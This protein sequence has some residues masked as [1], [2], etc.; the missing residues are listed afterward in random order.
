MGIQ[1]A[2]DLAAAFHEAAESFADQLAL[3]DGKEQLTYRQLHDR[4]TRAARAIGGELGSADDAPLVMVIL[5]PSTDLICA[6][7][8]TIAAGA[9]YLPVDAATPD[10]YVRT[11]VEDARPDLL[12]T[13]AA[14]ASRLEDIGVAVLKVDRL[15]R[16]AAQDMAAPK[17]IRHDDPAYVI[18]TSGSTGKPKGV[19]VGHGAMLNSTAARCEAYGVPTRMPLVHSIAFDLSSGVV[20]WALLSGGTLIINRAP[21]SDVPSTLDLIRRHAVTH[22]VYPAS[23]YAPFLDR[24]VLDPPTS[25]E[26]VM[27][28]S[29]R[30]SSVLIGRHAELLP[31]ASLHNEYG[32]SEA[33][34]W[35]SYACVY[36]GVTGESAALTL[37]KPI[38]NTGYLVR[39]ETGGSVAPGE[40]GELLI[41]G[42][43]LA[44]GY[45]RR[46]D[47]TAERFVTTADGE[48][49]YRTGDVVE[50]T[51]D[52]CYVFAGRIDR[53]L[54]VQGNRIEAGH[55][56]TLL[57]S[58]PDIQQAHVVSRDDSGMGSTLV[59][60][61][62]LRSGLANTEA[63]SDL[64]SHLRSQ[65]PAYMVPSAHVVLQ[66]LPRTLN[67]KIDESLLPAPS[68]ATVTEV[69]EPADALEADLV[70]KVGEI[71]GAGIGVET[72]LNTVGANSLAFVRISAAITGTH[73]VEIPMSALFG[74]PTVRAFAE[75]I[76]S[77]RRSDRPA[78]IPRGRH[79]ATSPL[80][81]QQHQ[82]W[83]LHHLSPNALAYN[84]Q[85][86]LRLTG[87]LDQRMLERALSSIV[88]RH[89]ILRTTF[90]D[91][92]DGPVQVVHAPWD[93]SVGLTDL[94]GIEP[95]HRREVMTEDKRT[96]M[97]RLFDIAELPLVR[98]QL[99]RLSDDSWE[100]FQS[101]HHFVHDGWSASL[102][103]KEI[104]DAYQAVSGDRRD[105]IEPL[106]VQYRDYARWYQ[107]WKQSKNFN[108]QAAYWT[109]KLD[110]C[111]AQ[112]VTF[113]S[114]LTRP[115]K[116]GFHGAC[117]RTDIPAE[118]IDR[119]DVLC[120]QHNVTRFAFFLA[121]FGILVWRYT[122]EEDFVIG[123]ALSNRRQS[124]TAPMLGMFV[125][126]LPL[127]LT[128]RPEESVSS[129]V[130]A[131]MRTILEAQDNQEF[132]LIEIIKRLDLP[133]DPA[134]NPLFQLMF[135]FHDS[136]RPRFELDGLTGELWIDHN[137][138][139]KNDLNVVCVPNPAEPGSEA[140][141]DG[142]NILWEYNREV[143]TEEAA[144][145]L[146]R[147]FE[148]I[149]GVIVE[150]WATPVAEVDLL[151][152]ES[153]SRVLRYGTGV[154]PTA[155]F[156]TLHGG[157]N[158]AI[159]KAPQLVAVRQDD[160]SVTYSDLD[161]LSAGIESELLDEGVGPGDVV[162]IAGPMSATVIA[163]W[164]AV[165]R[166]GATYLYVDQDS[167]QARI[168]LILAD[169][170]PAAIVCP[171]ASSRLFRRSGVKV[172]VP[173]GR[174]AVRPASPP[175][176]ED[177]PAYL[178]YTSGS[179]GTPKAVVTSHGNAVAALHARTV[180][181]GSDA[182]CTLVTL[183]AIF[184]VAGSMVFWTL[185][186]GGTVV[187]PVPGTHRD[188]EVIRSLV[189]RNAVSHVNFVASFYRQFLETVP[190]GWASSLKVIAIGGEACT[191]DLVA[192]HAERV[193]EAG[194]HN[195]YGPTEATVWCSAST[196]HAAGGNTPYGQ[197]TVGRPLAGYSMY[198]LDDRRQLVPVGARGELYVGG[199]GVALGYLNRPELTVDRFVTI[200]SG[201][202][203]GSRLYRTGDESRLRQNG[204][205]EIIG[206]LD[207]QVKIRGFRIETGEVRRCLTDHP[208]VNDA[209]V[210]AEPHLGHTRLVA[211]VSTL[212]GPEITGVLEDWLGSRLPSYMV[213]AVTV[214]LPSLPLTST[215][216]VDR[217]R[218]PKPNVAVQ[219]IREVV[220]AESPAQQ[221][222]LDLW[223]EVLGRADIGVDDDFFQIGGDSLQSIRLA[224]RARAE[225]ISLTVSQILQARTVRALAA[226]ASAAGAT[227]D[228]DRRPSGSSVTL[229]AIQNWFFDQEF[230]D[231]DHFNQARIYELTTDADTAVV[232]AATSRVVARHEAFRTR[233][234]HRT[235]VL[236]DEPTVSVE[237]RSVSGAGQVEDEME[238]IQ[239]SLDVEAGRMGRLTVFENAGGSERWLGVVLH[240]LVVDAVSW[241]I[242]AEEIAGAVRGTSMELPPGPGALAVP[243]PT[244]AAVAFWRQV[245]EAPKPRL[246]W[247]RS[248]ARTPF[249]GLAHVRRVHSAAATKNLVYD[250]PRLS[251]TSPRST[252]LA[253]LCLALESEDLYV[254]LEGHGRNGTAEANEI[255]G[256]L[257][258]MAPALLR[259]GE[260]V[261][262]AAT[263]AEF[264]RQLR[265]I[266]DDGRDF[267]VA[268]HVLRNTELGRLV[269]DIELPSITF[270]YLGQASGTGRSDV[271]R[272]S[273][274]GTGNAVGA[275]NVLPTPFDVTLAVR[276]NR[277]ETR[278]SFDPAVVDTGFAHAVLD[279]FE[280]VLEDAAR[281][282]ELTNTS[283]RSQFLVHPIGGSVDWYLP[284]AQRLTPEWACI[285]VAQGDTT[286]SVE[287]LAKTYV[288]GLR[289]LQPTGP[290]RLVGWSF[291]ATVAYQMAAE[292]ESQDEVVSRLSLLDPPPISDRGDGVSPLVSHLRMLLPG[293]TEDELRIAITQTAHLGLEEKVEA[294]GHRLVDK[295]GGEV[296]FELRQLGLL[297][298]NNEALAA[299]RP[300]V[301]VDAEIDLVYSQDAHSEHEADAWS[302]LSKSEVVTTVVAE[303][304]VSMLRN[305]T[306]VELLGRS[307]R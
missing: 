65:A 249:G 246:P 104:R 252:L 106:A 219:A 124:E 244:P 30:W 292:I 2:E 162:A 88:E 279:R 38:L 80:S 148:H 271:I 256:W 294:L 229:T 111:P 264:E 234:S 136:P 127:R 57:M 143:L 5:E 13:S 290:Y 150:H 117:L 107:E 94:R 296:D 37:G 36:N 21:L 202:L 226:V 299:W 169:A 3:V 54:K 275:E 224:A 222:L 170:A 163:S 298:R 147:D 239:H 58:H 157:V 135:A 216:K 260:A 255:V 187:L 196:V 141:H 164:L 180:F 251:A 166:R 217:A 103:L 121:A 273:T 192:L 262:L 18:Y 188:P 93:V 281:F 74:R 71:L 235:A 209:C 247:K 102:F 186:L 45:L 125:N 73:G 6:L 154:E 130:R 232:L 24:V 83:F 86:T 283:A 225:G 51:E 79:E 26:H 307:V 165:L 267:G 113:D 39:S 90:H 207:D 9:A 28:G 220:V 112:G 119:V 97:S 56:E 114:D 40:R 85:F 16:K 62:V 134:R 118:M 231:P 181:F 200:E 44:L 156:K 230:A 159:E 95:A 69:S 76:R 139:A 270:N 140:S 190:P 303:S 60:Y 223:Q 109:D 126:A 241:D 78:L 227:E 206:R 211:Y 253:A 19:V 77:A 48:R 70:A 64:D 101:E 27:I 212:A 284:L 295:P 254:Q 205:F 144:A 237:Q 301:E 11:V 221:K 199:A 185:S 152:A 29:E 174:R 105:A 258:T 198:V 47:L 194:L 87:D 145:S 98:W 66:Q 276:D 15:A 42:R 177:Q 300:H 201:P 116:Q 67:G 168:D 8:G 304:H 184:D 89:E 182:P 197:V 297:V 257:T 293:R 138:S 131:V 31:H 214:V 167:P 191:S 96:R 63:P 278:F 261:G 72:P 158:A 20:F 269:E 7:L 195:E 160:V 123:S 84:T 302:L 115:S 173:S 59:S 272:P 250:I 146:L 46:P 171:E 243:E 248:S 1:D 55:V 287:Q 280:R 142:L 25:L 245:A 43:N 22:L 133:R 265:A 129:H 100:L 34:V 240:H 274:L 155:P 91:G 236:G 50:V 17:R 92:P 203:A 282:V 242:L 10:E 238:A 151:S 75:E 176:T 268:R 122:A 228:R 153:Q 266:P 149:I 289:A 291:G 132:P 32:P 53:Q 213:P 204:D 108:E 4:V 277:L 175:Q 82:I 61:L 35:S 208:D 218:L 259:R 81:A 137:G 288:A 215:G 286:G 263:A 120:S 305:D 233:F 178:V 128:A 14:R 193:P 161:A 306:V 110:G 179:T 49:A 183:P 23:L 285:G 189:E 33:C 172:V 210:I 12:V 52:G 99:Y 41:S 68:C